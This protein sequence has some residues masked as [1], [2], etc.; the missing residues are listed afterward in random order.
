VQTSGPNYV[1]PIDNQY[2]SDGSI[3]VVKIHWKQKN[4]LFAV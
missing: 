4:N 2:G 3:W 1:L